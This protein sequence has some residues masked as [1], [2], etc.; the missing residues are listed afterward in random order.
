MLLLSPLKGEWL[1]A[2]TMY[3]SVILPKPVDIIALFVSPG[4]QYTLD[5]DY[6]VRDAMEI[7]SPETKRAYA[8]A[9][10]NE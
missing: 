3:P 6:I 8:E 1:R 7:Y 4:A 2:Y 5:G 10:L 9:L